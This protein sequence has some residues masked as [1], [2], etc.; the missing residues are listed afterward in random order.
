MTRR[1]L[2]MAI[3]AVAA[4]VIALG[5]TGAVGYGRDYDIHRGFSTLVNLPR[6][7]IGRLLDV[8]FYS[9]AL[10]RRADYLA[11]LPPG[12]TS[13][14]RYP[15]YYLLHGMP[16]QPRV[17]VDIANMDVRLDNQ[18]SLGHARPMVHPD[19]QDRRG[20][21][22]HR[23]FRRSAKSQLAD[24]LARARLRLVRG[25]STRR[26]RFHEW[27]ADAELHLAAAPDHYVP[28]PRVD[29]F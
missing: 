11:Y 26:E 18:L 1:A 28:L 17:F 10:H 5:A 27:Q 24:L 16:G 14:R 22:D 4:G 19:R 12:Y 13:A 2:R 25:E 29:S 9:R 7:G 3:A 21:R 15:V 6:A 8:H 20:A 23:D